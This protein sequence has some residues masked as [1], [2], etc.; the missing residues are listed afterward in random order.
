MD[1]IYDDSD[2]VQV[3]YERQRTGGWFTGLKTQAYFTQVD[4]WMTDEYRT[5]SSAMPR[6]W[7]MGTMADTQ[8]VGGRVVGIVREASVGL[9]AYER[10][11]NT[12]TELAGR[13]YRPQ[14][15]IPGVSTRAIGLFVERAW[16][17]S[18]AVTLTAGGRVDWTR[19]RADASKADTTL[20]LAYQG[21]DQLE[22]A[23]VLPA[24]KARL[25]WHLTDG[26]EVAGGLGH[27]AR[28][29]EANERFFALRRMGSDWVGNP[30]IDPSR[31][32]GADLALTWR[33]AGLQVSTTVFLNAIDGF[34]T[35]YDQGRRAV[36]PGVMNQVARSYANVD[37]LLRGLEVSAGVPIS[38]RVSVSGDLSAVRGTQTPRPDLGIVSEDLAEIPPVR[39]TARIR[40]DD[41]RL[42]A[43]AEGVFVGRQE[44]VDADLNELVT[45]GYGI[46]NVQ[47]GVR[48][49]PLS[50]TVGLSNVL[51][52]TY[53]EHLSYQRDP[54]RS[55]VFV[56]EPGRNAF[57][58]I[59]WRF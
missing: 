42:F 9:E 33:R 14:N 53:R 21:T 50:L 3:S 48:R 52:H 24:A 1:A 13:G 36:V 39:G 54:F 11:W 31:N 18:A 35:V 38:A 44:H 6:A 17:L 19:T 41:G 59:A 49:G 5:S 40:Y 34:I 7:S 47:G 27:T 37:A 46:A 56:N 25:S 43:V 45:P 20:Y 22:T 15:S 32:T 4:H 51:D 57:V 28:V 12:T 8:T 58:S 26:I 10:E 23:D 30:A 2:R 55:G 16:P 29:A